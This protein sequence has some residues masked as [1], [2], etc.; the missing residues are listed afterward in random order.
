MESYM[1]IETSA[2]SSNTTEPLQQQLQIHSMKN[3]RNIISK[4]KTQTKTNRIILCGSVILLT[5]S[6]EI[7]FL[8]ILNLKNELSAEDN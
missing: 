5:S 8:S 6:N 4:N 3:K 1:H 2:V 7:E